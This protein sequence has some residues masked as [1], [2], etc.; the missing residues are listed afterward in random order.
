MSKVQMR[1]LLKHLD[2][3]IQNWQQVSPGRLRLV[4]GILITKKSLPAIVVLVAQVT[5]GRQGWSTRMQIKTMQLNGR[6]E[7]T[8]GPILTALSRPASLRKHA[9]QQFTRRISTPK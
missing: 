8:D 4:T 2:E 9:D 7:S 1:M 3:F 5:R 6:N